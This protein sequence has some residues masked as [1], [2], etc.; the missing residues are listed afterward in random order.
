MNLQYLIK[1]KTFSSI[2]E[3]DDMVKE[4]INYHRDV[5]TASNIE[6]LYNL[7]RHSLTA[8]GACHLLTSTIAR[9]VGISERTVQ[10][11]TKVLTDLGIITKHKTV[12]RTGQGASIYVI[13]PNVK[14]RNVS[15]LLTGTCQSLEPHETHV[16][17]TAPTDSHETHETVAKNLSTSSFNLSVVKNVVNNVAAPSDSEDLKQLLRDAYKPKTQEQERDFSEMC[18]IAFGRLK[19]FMKL[20]N[21]PYLQMKD[22]VVRCMHQL[23]N[24]TGVNNPFAMYSKMI[25]RQVKQLFEEWVKP[26]KTNAVNLNDKNKEY[27]PAWFEK[28]NE[29]R[30]KSAR[31]MPSTDDNGELDFEQQRLMVLAK[32][33]S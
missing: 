8:Y 7:A 22:I 19:Q 29:E 24:K 18:K 9:E 6:V 13:A 30:N 26:V 2:K 21:L 11:S 25:E 32:L 28:R 33:N 4:H 12:K 17:L 15:H 23:M 1:Y 10:R 16:S 5:L 20:Y 31:L 3:M 27:V 14:T